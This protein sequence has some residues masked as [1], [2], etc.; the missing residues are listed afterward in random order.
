LAKVVFDR[1]STSK[2]G[3]GDTDLAGQVGHAG[4]LGPGEGQDASACDQQLRDVA[5]PVQPDALAGPPG[6]VRLVRGAEDHR[7]VR[8]DGLLAHE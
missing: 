8:P 1:A 4:R 5:L 2:V 6:Q 7:Q 3:L